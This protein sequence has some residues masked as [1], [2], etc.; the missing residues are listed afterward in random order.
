MLVAEVAAL[1]EAAHVEDRAPV[2][3]EQART[4]TADY[5]RC[6]PLGLPAPAVQD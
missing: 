6:V 2:L 5:C 3:E 4:L 1:G